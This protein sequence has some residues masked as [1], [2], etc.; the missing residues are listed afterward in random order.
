MA[1]I[2][3]ALGVTSNPLELVSLDRL[4]DPGSLIALVGFAFLIPVVEEV[5]LR[6]YWFDRLQA[7]WSALV[8]SL[9][10]GLTWATWH[11]PLTLMTGYF[12]ETTFQPE[13]WW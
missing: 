6:G 1:V 7:R 9:I 11:V 2:A 8:A 12:G 13:L 4:I 10:L 5:G 3:L